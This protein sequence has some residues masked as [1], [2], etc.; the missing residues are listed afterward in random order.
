VIEDGYNGFLCEARNIPSL[1]EAMEKVILLDNH[2]YE[3]MCEQALQRVIHQFDKSLVL[4][5]YLEFIQEVENDQ[6]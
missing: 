3:K 4:K 5:K 1:V 6:A 2:T